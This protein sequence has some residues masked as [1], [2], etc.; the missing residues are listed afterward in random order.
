ML[1]RFVAGGRRMVARRGVRSLIDAPVHRPL[2]S[3]A[4]GERC[5]KD[6]L[7]VHGACVVLLL[8]L[9]DIRN[10]VRVRIDGFLGLQFFVLLV[11]AAEQDRGEYRGQ[12]GGGEDGDLRMVV[13]GVSESEAEFGHEQRD[14]KA[15]ACQ[16]AHPQQVHPLELRVQGGL[17]ELGGQPRCRQDADRFSEHKCHND[18]DGHGVGQRRGQAVEPAHGDAGGEEREDRHGESGRKR[19]EAVFEDLGQ[20]WPPGVFSMLGAVQDRD[21]EGQ[22]HTG[23]GGVDA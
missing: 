19:A 18:A 6:C 7:H 22:D 17:G 13:G 12:D 11:P 14:G 1:L 20:T 21:R 5:R 9:V 23:D 2:E 3:W 8:L 4:S 16:Q 10:A 15:D